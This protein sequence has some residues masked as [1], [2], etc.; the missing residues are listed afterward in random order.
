MPDLRDKSKMEPYLV[1]S[2]VSRFYYKD[3]CMLNA[4]VRMRIDI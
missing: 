4:A 2:K 3:V 1:S